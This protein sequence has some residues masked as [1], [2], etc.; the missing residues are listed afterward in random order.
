MRL[1]DHSAEVRAKLD[2][3]AENEGELTPED[4]TELDALF[5]GFADKLAR[6]MEVAR[7]LELEAEA[8]DAESKRIGERAYAKSKECQ[9]LKDYVRRCLLLS[10]QRKIEAGTFV[11]SLRKG[12]TSVCGAQEALERGELPSDY[13]RTVV[14]TTPDKKAIGDALKQGREVPGCSLVVGPETLGVK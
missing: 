11:L 4:E 8:L 2:R 6:C 9:R 3:V 10:G 14:R 7:E 5:D 12:R 13:V 1:Y